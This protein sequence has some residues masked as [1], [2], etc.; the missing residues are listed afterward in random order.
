MKL[1]THKVA[2]ITGAGSGI[3][4]ALAQQLSTEGALLALSDVNKEGLEETKAN[5]KGTGKVI[6]T[7][8]DVADRGA[9]EQYAKDTIT[10]FGQV[11]M[12]FNNAGVALAQTVENCSYEDFEWLMNI[13]FWGVVYGTKSFLPHML[14]RPEA[15]IVNISSIF[16]I[17]ALPTQSQYNATKFAVRGFTESLRQEV[18]DSNLY[19]GCVHPGGIKTN[20]VVNGRMHASMLGEQ[21]HAQQ[22]EEFNKMARTTPTEAAHTILN[23]VR[24]NKRRILIGQDA[25][26]MDRVQRLFPEKYTS[27]FGAL[28]KLAR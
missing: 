15:A 18:K 10:E 5:L 27:I 16:G 6:L 3:G 4:R 23:G 26:F 21:T 13:N 17:I 22:I 2:V 7:T 25:K 24:K 19:V 20:I 14:T 9:F 8:L 28:L 12:L 11:D 1:F